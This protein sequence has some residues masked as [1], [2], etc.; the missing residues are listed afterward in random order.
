MAFYFVIGGHVPMLSPATLIRL[1]TIQVEQ[2]RQKIAQIKKAIADL[3]LL[4]GNLNREIS[5]DEA[6]TKIYDPAHFA[7]PTFAKAAI[8]R[9]DNLMRSANVLKIRLNVEKTALSAAIEELEAAIRL[10][11]TDWS[12]DQ[13]KTI[14]RRRRAQIGSLDHV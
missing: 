1:K 2:L 7:Y 14:G 3:E 8:Q 11:E 9:R 4:T 12:R 10:T 6:R 5:T 13:F